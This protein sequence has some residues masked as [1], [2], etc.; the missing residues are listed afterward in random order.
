LKS[1]KAAIIAILLLAAFL[2]LYQ[3]PAL[4]PGLN[5]DEAGNGA[6]AL[7]ISQGVPRLWWQIGGGKEPLWPYLLAVTTAW[8]GNIPLALRLPAALTGL[9]TVA[10]VYPLTVTMFRTAAS[11]QARLIA[12]LAMLALALSAWHLHF[13]RLGFRAILLPLLST[14]AFY[15]F[16]RGMWQCPASGLTDRPATRPIFINLLLTALFLALGIYS[17]LAG[18]LLP[19]IPLLFGGLFWLTKKQRTHARCF[20]LFYANLV[21]LTFV[22]LLPLVLYFLVNP[23]DL[24]ARTGTVSIFNPAWNQGDLA[25]TAWR[26]LMATLGTFVGARGDANPLVNL[27]GAPVIPLWLASFWLLGGLVSLFRT[28]RRRP[29]TPSPYTFVLLWWL[30][31]LMPAVLAPEGAPHHLR[32]LG[33][34]VPT[35]ILLGLGLVTAANFVARKLKQPALRPLL[36]IGYLLLLLPQT[37]TG[38]FVRWPAA[39]DFTLPFDLY[40]VRLAADIAAAPPDTTYILPM[41]IRAGREARHYTLDYLLAHH[42]QNYHYISVD[43]YNAESVLQQAGQRYSKLRVVRWTDD[44]HQEADAKEIVTYLLETNGFLVDQESFPIY[45]I[46]TYR[47]SPF[48]PF[49][50]L[51]A[52]DRPVEANFDGLLQLET[53]WLP[54]VAFPGDRMPVA[55]TLIPLAPMDAD[56]KISLRLMNPDGERI[57]QTDRVLLHTFHQGTSLWPPEPVNEYYLL[58]VPAEASLGKYTVSAVIYHPDSL[59]PLITAG[60]AELPLGQVWID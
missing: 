21:F 4:P 3:L 56:Y 46:E 48:Y 45:N 44:K 24:L 18:R 43:E 60:Q 16:W 50:S 35:Y 58:P 9:L 32:L 37:V 39:A 28:L 55:L 15:F 30:A 6:A 49:Q 29:D 25:G 1:P 19:L 7:D 52:I 53:V 38:Y 10:A 51:P 31:M 2:R 36:A 59:A 33:T 26:T 23:A 41:D 42:Q 5:F 17:Y 20:S 13:S 54:S 57:A 40:A 34:I 12:L 22:F 11:R 14:L 47:P 8:L 27:P